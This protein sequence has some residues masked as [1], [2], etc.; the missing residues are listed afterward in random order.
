[1]KFRGGVLNSKLFS[2]ANIALVKH[3][4][5]SLKITAFNEPPVINITLKNKFIMPYTK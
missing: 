3:A 5:Y 4:G 1:M 2:Q